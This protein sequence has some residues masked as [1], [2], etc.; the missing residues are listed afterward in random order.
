MC[1]A[2]KRLSLQLERRSFHPAHCTCHVGCEMTRS[3]VLD[4]VW[5]EGIC[6]DDV[7]E[8]ESDRQTQPRS[9]EMLGG[10]AS[11]EECKAYVVIRRTRKQTSC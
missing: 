1:C 8:T 7:D 6:D 2:R 5:S 11:E 4:Y 9:S 10:K 3:T